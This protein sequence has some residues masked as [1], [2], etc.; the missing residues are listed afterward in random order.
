MVTYLD[1]RQINATVIL[2]QSYKC[3]VCR[4]TIV[5]I[6]R[7]CHNC[8]DFDLCDSCYTLDRTAGS[9]IKS[10]FW[11]A[12]QEPGSLPLPQLSANSGSVGVRPSVQLVT[13]IPTD[14][15]YTRVSNL[16]LAS[17]IKNLDIKNLLKVRGVLRV[18]NPLWE[19]TYDLEKSNFQ[20]P[21]ERELWHG[22]GVHCKIYSCK[23]ICSHTDC[24]L[25]RIVTN[26]FSL[27][28]AQSNIR[29]GRFGNGIYFAPN[30][31]KSHDYNT[32]SEVDDVRAMLL[33]KVIMGT[34]FV[35]RDNHCHLIHPPSGYDSVTGEVGNALNYPECVVWN[36][37]RIL[38]THLVFY[39]YK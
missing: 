4:K 9:H 5:G 34:T 22:T 30:S 12:F 19:M 15:Q 7:R 14:G 20:N 3:D 24:A 13:A 39:S 8:V 33:C 37:K 35:T 31:S 28:K 25:C 23:S 6:R 27:S 2:Q 21:N 10:H 11:S 1:I 36:E 38:T 18:E 16:F 26:N 29:W 17:W 32:N